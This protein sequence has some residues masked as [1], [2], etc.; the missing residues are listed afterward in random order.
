[1]RDHNKA[2]VAYRNPATARKSANSSVEENAD[3]KQH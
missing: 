1:M 2:S 3:N